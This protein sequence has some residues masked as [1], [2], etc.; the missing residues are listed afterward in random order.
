GPKA[1]QV[2]YSV[3]EA[4]KA[5]GLPVDYCIEYPPEK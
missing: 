3:P 2:V 5:L 4:L 1:I